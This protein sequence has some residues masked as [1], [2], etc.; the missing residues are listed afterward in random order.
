MQPRRTA[1]V[2]GVSLALMGSVLA[3][4]AG[5]AAARGEETV[6]LD[7]A[8]REARAANARLPLPAL[9]IDI[10]TTREKEARA[11]R[12][13]KVA[14]E[15]D[16]IYAPYPG[17]SPAITN[18]G[19][20][21]LQAVVRQPIYAGGAL[22]AGVARAGA[23]V[24]AARARFRM[25]EKD[26]ELDVRSRYAELL[27]T[28]AEVEIRRAGIAELERYATSLRSR[29]AAG[30]G[31]S[32]DV[33]K[34]DVR[35]AL[36]EAALAET[37]QRRDEARLALNDLMGRDPTGSLRLAALAPPEAPRD[38]PPDAWKSAPDVVAAAASARS[39]DADT[40]IAAAEQRPRL[41]FTAD[42]GFLTDDTTHLNS[43]FWD[44]FW[45][46]GGY[47][48]ALVFVWP[49]WDPGAAKARVAEANLGLQQA[50]LQL[51]VQQRDAR[52]A[53]ERARSALAHL[54]RQVEILSRTVPAA[55]DSF[56]QAESRYRGGTASA[57]DVLDAHAAAL[58]AAVRKSDVTARYRVAEA[59]AL[60]W[61]TP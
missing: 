12:W 30:Q 27:E 55:N 40:T 50:R 16:F 42:T 49:V 20:A 51:E 58:D 11:E 33:L 29:Q 31:V 9:E 38:E 52:L 45:R 47:S 26:L 59:L 10:A 46:N 54:Y 23:S 24:E 60:R 53:W 15:G 37:E 44:H 41:A 17:Y 14:L 7:T 3:L 48:F 34:T 6:T 61:S 1:R 43:Q 8:L 18:L 35:R 13:L 28:D 2:A 32:A 56:L 4:S 22:D 21:R 36:E 19:E 57:L 39:A 5:G 25:A